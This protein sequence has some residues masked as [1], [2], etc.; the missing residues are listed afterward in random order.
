M[1]TE[2]PYQELLEIEGVNDAEDDYDESLMKYMKFLRGLGFV[3]LTLGFC[4]ESDEGGLRH[5]TAKIKPEEGETLTDVEPSDSTWPSGYDMSSSSWDMWDLFSS[6]D[7]EAFIHIYPMRYAVEQGNSI[8]I[9]E[10]TLC[11]CSGN[12]IYWNYSE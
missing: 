2:K 11:D 4:T 6:Y 9:S 10:P 5:V 12:E 1:K 3:E 7:M 8:Y